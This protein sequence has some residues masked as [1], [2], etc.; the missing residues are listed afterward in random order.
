MARTLGKLKAAEAVPGLVA[1]FQD[2]HGWVRAEAAEALLNIGTRESLRAV[3]NAPK[4]ANLRWYAAHAMVR[5]MK[6]GED[7]DLASIVDNTWDNASRYA[8]E[9]LCQVGRGD[10]AEAMVRGMEARKL[11]PRYFNFLNAVRRKTDW[12]RL[13][14]MAGG[15]FD[16]YSCREILGRFAERIGKKLEWSDDAARHR[17]LWVDNNTKGYIDPSLEELIV[18]L[19]YHGVC[20]LLE[21]DSLRVITLEE[22]L[23]F[24]K[25]WLAEQEKDD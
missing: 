11:N 22:A 19:S 20:I 10:V 4:G 17:D 21:E 16:T 24:W 13:G 8:A 1:L 6:K 23:D 18:Y 9:R 12:V 2:E 25:K 7:H 5:L 15:T 3:A 14:L